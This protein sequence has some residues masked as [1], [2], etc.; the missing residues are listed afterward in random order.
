MKWRGMWEKELSVL[1]LPLQLRNSGMSKSL[2]GRFRQTGLGLET[3]LER[4]ASS[5]RHA[6]PGA[7]S[8]AGITDA[9]PWTSWGRDYLC[10]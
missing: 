9:D 2:S 3:R 7:C 5:E 4:A 8:S 10:N 6:L 1:S